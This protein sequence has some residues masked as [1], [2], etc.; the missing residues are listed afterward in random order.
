VSGES[1]GRVEAIWLKR[2]K[3]GP[4]DAVGAAELVPE[5][6]LVGNANQGGRRQ[7]TIIARETWHELMSELDASI[8]PSARR[9]NLMVSGLDLERT[10]GGTLQVGE[11]LLEIAGETRPCEQMD[12]ALPGLRR[13]MQERWRGGVFAMVLKGGEIRIGDPV[14]LQ[15]T[16]AEA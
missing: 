7:V 9:A 14:I 5:R 2:A 8:A 16:D 6:G 4:M 1:A 3:G 12:A 15:L 10:R 13:A 11:A